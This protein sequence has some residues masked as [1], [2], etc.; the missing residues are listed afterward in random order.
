MAERLVDDTAV[1]IPLRSFVTAKERLAGA[2][3]DDA[4]ATLAR[5]MATRVADAASPRPA[6]IVSSAPEVVTWAGARNLPV[7]ADPGTLDAAADAGRA[8]A[9]ARGC[10]RVVIAHADLPLAVSLDSV[11]VGAPADTAV[12]VPDHRNDGTP[13]LSLPVDAPFRFAYGPGSAGRHIAE[14]ARCGLAVAIVHEETLAFDVDIAA[15]L[16]ALRTRSP[17][18]S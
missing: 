1:V 12:I 11:I 13:V 7:I 6:V 2:L 15:D 8:W 14:A 16:D 17:G 4:R 5:T 18:R 10:T 9:R 3:D